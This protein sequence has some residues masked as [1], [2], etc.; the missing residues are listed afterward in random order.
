[1][2]VCVLVYSCVLKA[3]LSVVPSCLS[4]PSPRSGRRL[5]GTDKKG[6]GHNK[7]IVD[8]REFR[9]SLPSL[10]HAAGKGR[11]RRRGRG[12]GIDTVSRW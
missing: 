8:V 4:L 3:Y 12:R 11:R 5:K 2:C 10:I 1:V 9:S 6:E 7:I